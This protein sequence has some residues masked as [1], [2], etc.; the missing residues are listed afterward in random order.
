[1]Q[2]YSGKK[3]GSRQKGVGTISSKSPPWHLRTTIMSFGSK[4]LFLLSSMYYDLIRYV[5]GR[6]KI[7]AKVV[8][9][10]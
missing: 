2:A 5:D 1:M 8:T 10:Q 4:K 6:L 7:P 3:D 9:T